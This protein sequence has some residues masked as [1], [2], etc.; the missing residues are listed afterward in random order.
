MDASVMLSDVEDEIIS[1]VPEYM[2]IR[3]KTHSVM[4]V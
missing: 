1:V 2:Q 4:E 3:Q